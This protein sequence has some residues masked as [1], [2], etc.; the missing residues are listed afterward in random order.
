MRCG[1]PARSRDARRR[2]CRQTAAASSV[3]ARRAPWLDALAARRHEQRR[4]HLVEVAHHARVR[5]RVV[6]VAHAID[7]VLVAHAEAQEETT[8]ERLLQRALGVRHRER[9][10]GVDVGDAR[11]HLSVDVADNSSVAVTN[12]SRPM[13]S[14]STASGTRALRG[15]PRSSSLPPMAPCRARPSRCRHVRVRIDSWSD[16]RFSAW[17]SARSEACRSRSSVSAATISA[18]VSTPPQPEPWSTPPSTRHQLVRHR[19]HLRRQPQ[20]TTAR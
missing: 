13:V 11:R 5:L 19:R 14:G 16:S 15:S 3:R 1:R 4:V 2:P 17:R 20:R 18:A 12:G 8:G 10:A 7:E 6:V 9:V